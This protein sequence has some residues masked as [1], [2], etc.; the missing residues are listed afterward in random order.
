M[1]VND[2]SKNLLYTNHCLCVDD[3]VLYLSGNNIE[4]IT[5]VLQVNLNRYSEWC[6]S[7]YLTLNVSK[8]KY[9]ILGTK[10]RTKQVEN[11]ELIVNN[12]LL[13][14]EPFHKI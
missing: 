4:D 5:E 3:T 14:K 9:V 11:V 10:Q 12:T 7:N 6:S 13:Y 8:T 1:Y 2:M